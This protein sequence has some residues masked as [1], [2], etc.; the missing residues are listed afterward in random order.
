MLQ[1]G[2]DQVTLR[3]SKYL[4]LWGEE[5]S[6]PWFLEQT[7]LPARLLPL[8]PRK[9]LSPGLELGTSQDTF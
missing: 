1:I 8:S 6:C 5:F 2:T 7:A 3:L 9:C 4:F